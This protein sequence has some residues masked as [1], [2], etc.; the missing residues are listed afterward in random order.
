[1]WVFFRPSMTTDQFLYEIGP[2]L[3]KFKLECI[4]SF[5]INTNEEGNKINII[6]YKLGTLSHS[7]IVFIIDCFNVLVKSSK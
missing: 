3:C 4:V 5:S 1:M 2:P 7:E 6:L